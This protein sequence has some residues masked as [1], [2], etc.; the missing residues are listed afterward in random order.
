MENAILAPAAAVEAPKA[1]AH[2]AWVCAK[3]GQT[4]E[5]QLLCCWTC[6]KTEATSSI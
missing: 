2:D 6:V 5:C 3:C 1:Q 4:I